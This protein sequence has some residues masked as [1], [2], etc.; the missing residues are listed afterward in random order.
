MNSSNKSFAENDY[1]TEASERWPDQYAESQRRLGKLT[2][3]QKHELFA[4]T[5]EN[6]Q[7]LA[8][9]FTSQLAVDSEEVQQAIAD[10]YGWVS[11]FWTPN[12]AAYIGLGEMYVSDPRFAANYDKYAP[13]LAVFMRDA[14]AI[15]A[16]KNL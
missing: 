12:Q 16:R 9:L 4:R 3:A 5:E 13:G 2:D 10:H 7:R 1:A 8:S 14:M 6:H 15:W 11:A